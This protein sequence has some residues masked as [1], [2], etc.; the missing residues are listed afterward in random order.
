M[1][2]RSVIVQNPLQQPSLFLMTLQKMVEGSLEITVQ[3]GGYKTEFGTVNCWALK[4]A[5][6]AA[7][8]SI[9]SLPVYPI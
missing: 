9:C 3:Q 7:P 4:T 8:F 6:K 5:G 1:R 2:G